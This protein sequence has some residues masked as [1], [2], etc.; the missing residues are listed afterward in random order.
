MMFGD[1]HAA[2]VKT[3]MLGVCNRQGTCPTSLKAPDYH[4]N[5]LLDPDHLLETVNPVEYVKSFIVENAVWIS[6]AVIVWE[7][8]KMIVFL[9]SIVTTVLQEGLS[10]LLAV[11]YVII[12]GSHLASEQVMRKGKRRK[13]KENIPLYPIPEEVEMT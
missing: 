8:L 11:M 13:L 7:T 2:I 10:R 4:L 12:C 3:I 9:S 5:N 6:L 1:L